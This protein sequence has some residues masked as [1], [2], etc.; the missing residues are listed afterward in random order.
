MQKVVLQMSQEQISQLINGLPRMTK[1]DLVR[2]WEKE[3]WPDRFRQL[4][5]RIDNH[6]RRY[7]QKAHRALKS[8]DS[9]RQAFHARRSGH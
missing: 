4:L 7:P 9:I 6:V 1:I 5:S 8:I 2:R 3:L